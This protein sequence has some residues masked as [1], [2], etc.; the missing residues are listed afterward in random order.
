M[1]S[2]RS[3]FSICVQQ[4]YIYTRCCIVILIGDYFRASSNKIHYRRHQCSTLWQTWNGLFAVPWCQKCWP[5]HKLHLK[6]E[7]I[8]SCVLYL[9]SYTNSTGPVRK[10]C[11]IFFSRVLDSFKFRPW[12]HLQ[13][14][15]YV[16]TW[17]PLLFKVGYKFSSFLFSPHLFHSLSLICKSNCLDEALAKQHAQK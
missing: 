6:I 17:W 1:L 8:Y 3:L 12:V 15:S 13:I 11:C 9:L 16:L 7:Q 5:V 4:Y 14:R 2:R 10:L